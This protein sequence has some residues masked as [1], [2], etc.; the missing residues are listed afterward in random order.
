MRRR[1]VF[2]SCDHACD[3][4]YRDEFEKLFHH[5]FDV[6]SSNPVS[7]RDFPPGLPDES[8]ARL[9]RTDYLRDSTVTVVLIG[10]HTW[11]RKQVDWEICS[12]LFATDAVPCS[13]LLGLL[14]PTHP[15]FESLRYDPRRVPPRLFDN[16]RCQFAQIHGWTTSAERLEK[17]IDEAYARRAMLDPDLSRPCLASDE[18][19]PGWQI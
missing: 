9:M 4:A 2:V 1:R 12:T 13:G 19:G 3:T 17:W 10:E 5:R 15:D 6:L 16:A 18:A 11:Q 7:S 14:L 8:I